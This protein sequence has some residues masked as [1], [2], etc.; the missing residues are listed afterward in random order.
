M[1]SLRAAHL[2]P[3]PVQ[4]A[5]HAPHGLFQEYEV[6]VEIF[7][8][9]SRKELV[10]RV[11]ERKQGLADNGVPSPTVRSRSALSAR[12]S[13]RLGDHH[14]RTAARSSPDPASSDHLDSGLHNRRGTRH[15]SIT[16]GFR[17]HAEVADIV[18]SAAASHIR[19]KSAALVSLSLGPT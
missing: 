2:G 19:M 7:L 3:R 11:D 16:S 18:G 13:M 10:E 6:L 8:A 5:Q 14:R 1:R 15:I 4:R 9:M 17:T 12:R